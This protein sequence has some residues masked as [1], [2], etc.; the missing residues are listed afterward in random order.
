MSNRLLTTE[1]G[2]K[3]CTQII[4]GRL[5]NYSMLQSDSN[6]WEETAKDFQYTG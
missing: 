3:K 2:T 4:K 1:G 5:G 6:F